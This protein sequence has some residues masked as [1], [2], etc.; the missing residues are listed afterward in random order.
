MNMDRTRIEAIRRMGDVLAT[1]CREID[2]RLLNRLFRARYFRELSYELAQAKKIATARGQQ[3]FTFDDLVEVFAESEDV[4]RLDWSVA[5]DLV[6]IRM[7]D[8]LRDRLGESKEQL[9]EMT[10]DVAAVD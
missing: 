1:Y 6:L 10:R 2:L 8:Q 5:R 9:E 7:F 3:L 4:P